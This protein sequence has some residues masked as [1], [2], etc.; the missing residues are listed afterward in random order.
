MV[1]G[2][3]SVVVAPTES[4]VVSLQVLDDIDAGFPVIVYDEKNENETPVIVITMI[5][6]F[7]VYK[8]EDTMMLE[9]DHPAHVRIDDIENELTELMHADHVEYIGPPHG[10]YHNVINMKYS[11]VDGKITPANVSASAT[12]H[13][14]PDGNN[15]VGML[16]E[17]H[18]QRGYALPEY[19]HVMSG[20]SHMPT[21]T[22]TCTFFDDDSVAHSVQAAD[23][24]SVQKVKQLAAKLALAKIRAM[25][26]VV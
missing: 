21:F 16:Q 22:V 13:D 26:V 23:M 1:E 19:I 6:R 24:G 3:D 15:Y 20:P 18:Q 10:I 14:D 17:F 11:L 12:S 5:T 9:V 2:I 25:G 4:K 8:D 7:R